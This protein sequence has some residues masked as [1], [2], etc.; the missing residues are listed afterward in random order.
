MKKKQLIGIINCTPDSFFEGGRFT[1][2]ELAIAHGLQLIQEGADILDIG[3]ESTRPGSTVAVSAEEELERILPV[4]QGIRKQHP[5]PLS[6]DTFK[7]EVA[8]AAVDAGASWI[9]DITGFVLPEMRQLA[10]ESG[11][12]CCITHMY[13]PPH[14]LPERIDYPRGIVEEISLYFQRRIALLLET[15]VDPERIVLDPGIGGGSFGKSPEESLLLIKSITKFTTLGYP[16][17]IGLSRKSFL[18][19]ILKKP[20]SEVLSTTLAL[21]T[22]ALVGGTTYIRVHDVA[23][24]RDILTVLEKI[25]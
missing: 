23:P 14:T 12:M 24:H 16:L 3:G 9:N 8:R 25:A 15:G 11:A 20:A 7:P 2:S 19:K 10:A 21:N 17:L 5:I 13:S 1:D 22:M 4:I 6:V 18:Q